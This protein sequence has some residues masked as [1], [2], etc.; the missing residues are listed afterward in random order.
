MP[1]LNQQKCSIFTA[2]STIVSIL[3]ILRFRSIFASSIGWRV[4]LDWFAS[5]A[6]RPRHLSPL[7]SIQDAR[8]NAI[9]FWPWNSGNEVHRIFGIYILMD[10]WMLPETYC[11][12]TPFPWVCWIWRLIQDAFPLG[13][14]CGSGLEF[15][16]P[17][18]KCRKKNILNDWLLVYRRICPNDPGTPIFLT[19]IRS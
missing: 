18:C 4:D 19:G 1:W 6:L 11:S 8:W 5:T 2:F 13:N 10:Y 3:M 9:S 12:Q 15:L 7:I 17:L 16:G 14:S